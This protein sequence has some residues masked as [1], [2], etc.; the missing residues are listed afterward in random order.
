MEEW[1]TNMKEYETRLASLLLEARHL[2]ATPRVSQLLGKT[3]LALKT[4]M[5]SSGR[6]GQF[7]KGGVR[8]LGAQSPW[9]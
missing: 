5:G 6:C 7:E 4:R 3:L 9:A 8:P 1:T 2:S